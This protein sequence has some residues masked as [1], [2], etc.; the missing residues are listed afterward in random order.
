MTVTDENLD[1][2]EVFFTYSSGEKF[3]PVSLPWYQEN[4]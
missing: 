4:R 3:V 1:G 2:R